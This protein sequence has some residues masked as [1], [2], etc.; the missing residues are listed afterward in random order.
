MAALGRLPHRQRTTLVLRFFEDLPE[1][2]VAEV[3][4]CSV[5]TVK[6][7]TSKALAKLRIDPGALAAA[8][9]G[10]ECAHHLRGRGRPLKGGGQGSDT[11]G[12]MNG[13]DRYL[14]G[15]GPTPGDWSF[16]V[17]GGRCDSS[18]CA[19]VTR[20][21]SQPEQLPV[22]GPKRLA[23][24]SGTADGR[25]RTASL[26]GAGRSTRMRVTCVDGAAVAVGR[27]GGRSKSAECESAEY[28][29]VVWDQTV[30][31]RTS[32]IEIAVLPAEAA[33]QASDMRGTGDAALAS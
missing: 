28:T 24:V 14:S 17:Y 12:S 19:M 25:A 15:H 18:T 9:Q 5:G 13:I 1:P 26:K 21:P 16:G 29:G 20:P 8:R 30:E 6:S 31:D 23:Q 32:R 2:Q 22:A 4:D 10:G 11:F 27:I 7:Q 33:W 3:L